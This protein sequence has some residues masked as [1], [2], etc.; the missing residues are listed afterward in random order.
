P[1]AARSAEAALG[2]R[3][4]QARRRSA[5]RSAAYVGAAGQEIGDVL[6]ADQRD[7]APRRALD[8]CR[9]GARVDRFLKA[10]AAQRR[11]EEPR[12]IRVARSNRIDDLDDRA[13]T[14]PHQAAAVEHRG[15]FFAALQTDRCLGRQ[16]REAIERLLGRSRE[17]EESLRLSLADEEVA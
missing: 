5:E 12:G 11:P 17:A 2:A 6:R 9:R 3:L 13:E 14:R 4:Y 10:A 8:R 16:A 15:A 7:V 1:P